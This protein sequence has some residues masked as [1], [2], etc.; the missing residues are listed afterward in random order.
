MQASKLRNSPEL[1][2]P[3]LLELNTGPNS[4]GLWWLLL[5]LGPLLFFQRRLQ[6]EI[7]GIL[8]LITRRQDLA[9]AL[10]SLLFFPGILLHEAS[11]YLA[12]RVLFVRTGRVS[13]LPQ[14]LPN[15]RL[16]MGYVETEKVD[17]FRDA[18]IGTAPL[19]AGGL[20][21]AWIGLYQLDLDQFWAVIRSQGILAGFQALGDLFS[22]ADFW[23]WLYLAFTISNTMFPSSSDR[24]AWLPVASFVLLLVG[25]SLLLGAGQW[26]IENAAGPFNQALLAVDVVLGI[27]LALHVVLFIPLVL[28]RHLLSRLTGFKVQVGE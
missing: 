15:G 20:V 3:L 13:L 14:T 26:M 2:R 25:L 16:R 5:L 19:L 27:S 4:N 17:W 24:R 8:L 18:L 6:F 12:A 7:Q 28:L 11:H 9:I 22:R 21:V 23:L 1:S 10:F